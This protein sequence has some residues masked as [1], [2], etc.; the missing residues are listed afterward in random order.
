M[1]L[2]LAREIMREV[3]RVLRPGGWFCISV[4]A[5]QDS[6]FG[7]GEEIEPGTFMLEGDCE[8]GLPQH[9]FSEEEM[10]SLAVGFEEPCF[11][12]EERVLGPDLERRYS[13]WYLEARKPV[14]GP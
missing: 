14:G 8:G 1:P 3:R 11:E 10:L 13:R 9:F 4:R 2:A 12:L 7:E 6:D 5:D